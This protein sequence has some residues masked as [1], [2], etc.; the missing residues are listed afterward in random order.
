[1]DSS[2]IGKSEAGAGL[3]WWKVGECLLLII[4]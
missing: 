2:V 1:V 4:E 3:I